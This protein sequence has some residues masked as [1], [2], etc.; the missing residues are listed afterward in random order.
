MSIT[1][2]AFYVMTHVFHELEERDQAFKCLG[3]V[4]KYIN[5]QKIRGKKQRAEIMS[6][7]EKASKSRIVSSSSLSSGLSLEEPKQAQYHM[8]SSRSRNVQ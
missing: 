5:E 7:L 4:E 3:Q 2:G 6:N 1:K 8:Q